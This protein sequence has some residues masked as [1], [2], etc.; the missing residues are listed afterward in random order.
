MY[1]YDRTKQASGADRIL[2]MIVRN[3]I[4]NKAFAGLVDAWEEEVAEDWEEEQAATSLDEESSFQFLQDM[5]VEG[6]A[7]IEK[8]IQAVYVPMYKRLRRGM[9]TQGALETL[10]IPEKMPRMMP[11]PVIKAI[12]VALARNDAR[13]AQILQDMAMRRR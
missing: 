12:G 8:A 6:E 2:D 7:A 4:Q 1:S 11:L 13:D 3:A 9:T 5:R 10:E